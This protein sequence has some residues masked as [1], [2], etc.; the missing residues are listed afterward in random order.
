MSSKTK[1]AEEV[2]KGEQRRCSLVL[3]SSLLF[4]FTPTLIISTLICKVFAPVGVGFAEAYLSYMD[5]PLSRSPGSSVLIG[6]GLP[7][8]RPSSPLGGPHRLE[9]C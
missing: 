2:D 7:M 5:S 1:G 6:V 8:T 3:L 9:Y 4:T